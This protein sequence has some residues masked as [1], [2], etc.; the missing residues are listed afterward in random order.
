MFSVNSS[1]NAD[2]IALDVYIH[3]GEIEALSYARMG[4]DESGL[5]LL[6]MLGPRQRVR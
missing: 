1:D 6:K 2:H 4:L 3:M 5:K